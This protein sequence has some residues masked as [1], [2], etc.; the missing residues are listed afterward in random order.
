MRITPKSWNALTSGEKMSALQYAAYLTK[1]K[2]AKRK[3]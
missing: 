3:C 1:K 2:W